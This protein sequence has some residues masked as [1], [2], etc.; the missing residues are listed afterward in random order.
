MAMYGPGRAQAIDAAFAVL[1]KLL[2]EVAVNAPQIP[3]V[4]DT[5]LAE[6]GLPKA[7]PPSR[8][9]YPAGICENLVVRHGPAQG[10]VLARCKP[11]GRTI[12]IYE[13]Q[14][15]LDPNGNDWIDLGTFCNSRAFD[16]NGLPRGKDVWI[17][18]R[19]RNIIGPGPWSDPATIMVT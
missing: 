12:R 6:I 15:T 19:A 13:A 8:T 18:V 7:K 17:R 2:A 16:F 10:Q 11:A 1:A 5:D 4:T 3:G 9:I 14:W